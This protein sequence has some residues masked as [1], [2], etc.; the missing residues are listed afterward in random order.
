MKQRILLSM[1][2]A[3]VGLG[4]A[5]CSTNPNKAEKIDT[6]IEKKA[7]VSG[8]TS[9]GVKDGNMVVQKKVLMNEELRHL[10]NEV[11]S[12]E[13]RV[14]GNRDYGSLGLYGVL[15]QCRADLS[16]RKNGGDGKLIWTEPVDRITAKEDEFNIGIDDKD[17]IVGVKEEFLRDRIERFKNY[18]MV[19]EKRQDEYE[20]KITICQADLKSRQFDSTASNK[21]VVNPAVSGEET[22]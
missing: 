20:G 6:A 8:D 3:V 7:E 10:Q 15:R 21:K 13:D 11:Y 14:Y 19:L 2:L 1:S 16:D 9:L 22:N 12:L 5:A 18:R 4:L 17:K